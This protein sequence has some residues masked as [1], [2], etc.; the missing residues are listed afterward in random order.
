VAFIVGV[1]LA[2]PVVAFGQTVTAAWDPN[3]A[4]DGVLNYEICV[5]T[6]SGQLQRAHG[7]SA[8][9]ANDLHIQSGAGRASSRVGSRGSVQAVPAVTRPRSPYRFQGLV[10]CRTARARSTAAIAPI[11]I[12]ATDPDG[13][14]ITYTHTGLPFGLTLNSTTGVISGT[15]SSTG[16]YNVSIIANDGLAS[17]TGSFVWT[18]QNPTA[19]TTAPTLTISSHTSGQTVTTA[20]ITLAGTATDSGVGGSGS[21]SS[22]SMA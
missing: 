11:T 5:G 10:R 1:L 14:T 6:T 20:N 16:T 12:T 3:P 7:I 13:G 22:R 17:T 8:R 21:R 15:P 19:D 9:V 18:V 2:A 4:S